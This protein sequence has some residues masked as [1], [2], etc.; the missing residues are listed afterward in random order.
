MGKMSNQQSSMQFCHA[1]EAVRPSFV[2]QSVELPFEKNEQILK[3]RELSEQC[4]FL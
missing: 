3:K 1:L 2:V 4:S